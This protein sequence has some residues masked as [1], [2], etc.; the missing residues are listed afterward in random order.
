LITST[1]WSCKE[2]AEADAASDVAAVEDVAAGSSAGTR[3]ATVGLA[4]A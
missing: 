2:R 3:A 1:I 4:D